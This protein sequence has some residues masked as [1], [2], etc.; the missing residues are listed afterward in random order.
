MTL[1]SYI[2]ILDYVGDDRQCLIEGEDV[3]NQNRV[4]DVQVSCRTND[5]VYEVTAVCAC[6]EATAKNSA[7]SIE[8][9]QTETKTLS[10]KCTCD[11]HHLRKCH[12]VAATLIYL[13]R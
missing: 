5:N 11:S 8:I 1:V 3:F 4:E 10:Y 2:D 12:H 13:H 7:V 9:S 6:Q